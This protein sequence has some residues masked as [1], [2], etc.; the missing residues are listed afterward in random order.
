MF[1]LKLK[2]GRTPTL[3]S[4]I[5][6]NMP[7]D[8]VDILGFSNFLTGNYTSSHLQVP[9]KKGRALGKC[10]AIAGT[11]RKLLA[12]YRKGCHTFLCA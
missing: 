7:G 8:G 11:R 2:K 4:Q 1:C 6:T 10:E 9:R 5:L 3:N 12:V